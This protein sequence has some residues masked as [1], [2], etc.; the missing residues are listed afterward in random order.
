M[1]QRAAI[2]T[3]LPAGAGLFLAI[4]VGC[5]PATD[6]PVETA[7]E[8]PPLA[9]TEQPE[10]A[11]APEPE[12]PALPPQAAEPVR[13]PQTASG[14]YLKDT[15]WAPGAEGKLVL[16]LNGGEYP[17]YLASVVR[18]TQQFLFDRQLYDGP[19]TGIL[20][21]TT[22]Q[23]IAEFQQANGIVASGVPSPETRE[24]MQEAAAGEAPASVS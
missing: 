19:V 22:M 11:P 4:A 1:R 3:I 18:E 21:E 14:S 5:S 20:D 8:E 7:Q 6:A 9:V 15:H 12:T 13:E 2:R 16:G 23:A 24:A 17:P 10:P